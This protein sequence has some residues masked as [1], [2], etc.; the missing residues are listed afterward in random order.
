MQHW[1]ILSA[2]G[3]DKPGLVARWNPAQGWQKVSAPPDT[4]QTYAFS[5]RIIRPRSRM[6]ALV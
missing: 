4:H 1:F 5:T 6:I 3:R 2:I